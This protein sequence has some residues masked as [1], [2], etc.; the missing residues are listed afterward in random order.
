MQPAIRVE[1]L[2][3][4]YRG[5]QPTGRYRTVREALTVAAL[6]PLRALRQAWG[7]ECA[8]APLWALKDVSFEIQPGEVVGVIGRNGAGNPRSS[9]WAHHGPTPA[10]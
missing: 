10:G 3:K 1:D 7:Q 2:C 5:G 8:S 6:A 9:V 4:Q